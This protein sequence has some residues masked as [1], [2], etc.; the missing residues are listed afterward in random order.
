MNPLQV[1]P[2]TTSNTVFSYQTAPVTTPSQSFINKTSNSNVHAGG[3][4]VPSVQNGPATPNKVRLA[5]QYSIKF[6]F[7]FLFLNNMW[8]CTY[9]S[10]LQEEKCFVDFNNAYMYACMRERERNYDFIP[11]ITYATVICKYVDWYDKIG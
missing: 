3:N 2:P 7:M 1:F 8:L 5:Q 4:Q 9:C 10:S 11:L 6:S